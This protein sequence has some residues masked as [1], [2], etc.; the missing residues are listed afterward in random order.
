MIRVQLQ[1]QRHQRR[2]VRAAITPLITAC[3]CLALV[4]WIDT[5]VGLLTLLQG[6]NLPALS[7]PTIDAPSATSEDVIEDVEPVV[8]A[9]DP[10]PPVLL[11]SQPLPRHSDACH[12]ALELYGRLPRR[13]SFTSLSGRVTDG[14]GGEY[15][16]EGISEP[17]EVVTL[18]S[19][20]DTLKSLPSEVNLSYWREGGKT[21]GSYRFTFHGTF[22]D[23]ESTG[24]P[25]VAMA[26]DGTG[27]LSHVS[28]MAFRAGLDSLMTKGPI[29]T[30]LANGHGRLRQKYWAVGTYA[31]IRTFARELEEMPGNQPVL[32][33]LVVMPGHGSSK[34]QSLQLY[35][36][37]DVVVAGGDR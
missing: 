33:E 5:R 26:E 2:L 27:L 16:L 25:A 13:L 32:A 21:G 9:D 29:S 28:T 22:G 12:R 19:F 3:I 14:G 30:P 35:A 6:L 15:T 10:P 8:M 37:L 1:R 24:S 34:N 31:Q 23:P 7:G 36:A 20:L 18:F 17:E 11:E 4:H